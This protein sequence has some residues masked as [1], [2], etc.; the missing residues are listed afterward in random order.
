MVSVAQ[1]CASLRGVIRLLFGPVARGK[2]YVEVG[3]VLWAQCIG[4][5]ESLLEGNPLVEGLEI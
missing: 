2:G 1:R 3:K 4:E 5:V